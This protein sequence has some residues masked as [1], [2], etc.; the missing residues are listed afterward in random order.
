MLHSEEGAVGGGEVDTVDDFADIQPFADIGC[1]AGEHEAA[2]GEHGFDL[3]VRQSPGADGSHVVFC[4]DVPVG[5]SACD[6]RAG[7]GLRL[8]G[9]DQAC[10]PEGSALVRTEDAGFPGGVCVA[11]VVLVADILL[12]ELVGFGFD[13]LQDEVAA[14]MFDGV[15]AIG[16]GD[17]LCAKLAAG[18]V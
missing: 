14:G 2:I 11:V 15:V 8:L 5:R 3:I 4:G 18:S 6:A 7:A 17:R 12:G 10:V 9:Q 13:D 16:I 1:G